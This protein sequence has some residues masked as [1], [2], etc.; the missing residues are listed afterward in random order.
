MEGDLHQRRYIYTSMYF[1]PLPPHGGRPICSRA[2][3]MFRKFQSTPS[4]WRETTST[5]FTFSVSDFNP[6]PPHG[7][8]REL[9]GYK[10][11][12]G[13][14]NPLPP[15]GGR[16]RGRHPG[17]QTTDYFNPLPPHGGRLREN[18]SPGGGLVFQSTPSAWRETPY[19]AQI[20]AEEFISIHSLRMEGDASSWIALRRKLNF[21][22][23]PPHGGRPGT[24]AGQPLGILFQSTPSAWRE[25]FSGIVLISRPNIS[26]HSL[27]M[28]GDNTMREKTRNFGISIHSLRMEGDLCNCNFL[29]HTNHFNPLPPHGGRLVFTSHSQTLPGISIH[30]LRMEGD[31]NGSVDNLW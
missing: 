4:A 28:E 6:L 2:D 26:I 11:K 24:G 20:P 16:L 1:N 23:L 10:W 7:G 14:F 17:H 9:G 5:A 30:S 3:T 27:R 15:H 8:R 29:P 12:N 19:F 13:D 18:S 22:P 21:N 31:C 25:T